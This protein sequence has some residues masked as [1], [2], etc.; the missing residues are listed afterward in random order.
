MISA[1][2]GAP[3]SIAYIG[4]SYLKETNDEGLGYAALQ[5]RAGKFVLPTPQNI[6]AAANALESK[7][8]KDQRISLINAPG[9]N[10]YPIVNYEY[11]IVN[12][13]QGANGGPLKAFLLWAI[14]PDGGNKESYLAQVHFA[15]LPPSIAKLSRAQI[16]GIK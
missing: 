2:K 13:Q 15:P 7:T 10:S 3:Y 11:A 4:I 5:N 1:A 12:P 14:S 6:S 9:P 8:P 16:E